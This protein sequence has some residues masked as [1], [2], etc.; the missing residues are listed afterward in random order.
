MQFCQHCITTTTKSL[1]KDSSSWYTVLSLTSP[2]SPAAILSTQCEVTFIRTNRSFIWCKCSLVVWSGVLAGHLEQAEVNSFQWPDGRPVL[3]VHR[4]EWNSS[5]GSTR[6]LFTVKRSSAW[7][8]AKGHPLPYLSMTLPGSVSLLQATDDTLWHY[9][10]S[11][12][13]HLRTSCLKPCRHK[14]LLIRC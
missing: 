4:V 7:D 12:H 6:E 8:V 3:N 14:V 9:D 11:G 5:S 2:T 10:L 13:F 1:F